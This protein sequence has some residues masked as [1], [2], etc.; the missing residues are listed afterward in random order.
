MNNN[1]VMY[2]L[3]L[4]TCENNESSISVFLESDIKTLF[5]VYH[6]KYESETAVHISNSIE[7]MFVNANEE[8][9]FNAEDNNYFACLDLETYNQSF[10][11]QKNEY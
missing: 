4:S 10:G 11:E 2:F 9:N 5:K 3:Y 8:F 7:D 6:E 1:T